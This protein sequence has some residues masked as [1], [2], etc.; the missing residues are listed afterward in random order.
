MPNDVD[1]TRV[2]LHFDASDAAALAA[3]L[4]RYV[5]ATR[6]HDGCRNVDFCA[7]VTSPNRF[8]IIEKWASPAA[9]RAHFDSPDMVAMAEACRGLLTQPP[10]I[11]LLSGVSAHDLQ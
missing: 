6:G 9:Q 10:A 2:T 4:A 1:I 7:S 11:E 3:V 5:V 8:V